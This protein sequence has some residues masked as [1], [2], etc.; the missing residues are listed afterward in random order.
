M[1]DIG[2]GAETPERSSRRR[3]ASKK[4]SASWVVIDTQKRSDEVNKLIAL[5]S[6]RVRGQSRAVDAIADAYEAYLSGKTDPKHPLCTIVHLGPSG[7]GK[8]EIVRV[9][10]EYLFGRGTAMTRIDASEYSH[11][12][13]VARLTGSPPGFVRSDE[14]PVLSQERLDQPGWEALW[15][16]K[17]GGILR[18]IAILEKRHR[19]VMGRHEELDA[20]LD[21]LGRQQ[22][23]P[24]DALEE[25][26]DELAELKK[27]L[28]SIEEEHSR[29]HREIALLQFRPGQE[30]Y[31]SVLLVD[32][33]EKGHSTLHNL[34][35]QIMDEARITL[36]TPQA[37]LFGERSPNER[38]KSLARQATTSF[39]SCF[40][41]FTSNVGREAIESML[42]GGGGV[43]F[44]AMQET[45]KLKAE[46]LSQKIY[47]TATT[48][49][50][51]LFRPEFRGRVDTVVV[52]RPFSEETMRLILLDAI[53][54]VQK[55]FLQ[56]EHLT[57]VVDNTTIEYFIQDIQKQPE[58]GARLINRKVESRLQRPLRRALR[59]GE[60]RF[61]DT[62]S[63]TV[64]Q[65][66]QFAYAYDVLVRAE[67]NEVDNKTS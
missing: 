20:R 17:Q 36:N 59:S 29:K 27:E 58:E 57:V 12:H 43:G 22:D 11:G 13:E 15:K 9:F 45:E 32:E 28:G 21:D 40:I 66:G 31:P 37:Q 60:L 3:G 42:R 33:I 50:R 56:D 18:E 67:Q 26:L 62:V 6:Q 44:S 8:T 38:A 51:K 7:V 30:A 34:F 23:V 10:T 39:A 14:T 41:F 46:E 64:S 52:F 49:Y 53:T 47:D 19:E 24:D 54:R 63:V 65:S 55:T 1:N 2:D 48:A 61:G 5:L 4:N 16:P 35:L 25:M